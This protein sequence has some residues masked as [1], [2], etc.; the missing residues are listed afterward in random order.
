MS[1]PIRRQIP[2]TVFPDRLARQ[3]RNNGSVVPDWLPPF[4]CR[5]QRPQGV[6]FAAGPRRRGP[7]L[8]EHAPGG[9]DR[10]ERIGLAA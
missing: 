3:M 6:T 5:H 1:R 10:I 9:A 7:L 8:A 4:L 2:E